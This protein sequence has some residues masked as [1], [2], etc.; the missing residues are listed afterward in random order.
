MTYSQQYVEKSPDLLCEYIGFSSFSC[1]PK[2]DQYDDDYVFEIQFIPAEESDAIL[3]ERN[4]RIQ[5]PEPSD[6][7]DCFSYGIKEENAENI[8]I[9]EGTL[10]FCF[11]SFQ[12]IKDNYHAVCNQVSS[13]FDTDHLEESQILAHNALPLVL[14]P[15]SA[16]E[17]QISEGDLE[18]APYDQRIQV[19]SMPLYFESSELFEEEGSE[20]A[21][22]DQMI[23]GVSLP[24]CFKSSE[25]FKGEEQ[26]VQ[27]S[28][29]PFQPVCNELQV[30]FH[31]LY[32]SSA[33]SLCD[34]INQLSS[35]LAGY[36]AQDQD[37]GDF[38]TPRHD[39]Y[40]NPLYNCLNHLNNCVYML[41]DPFVQ[42][43]D[44]A[45]KVSSFLIFS[46]INKAISDCKISILN[47]SKHRQQRSLMFIMLKWLHWLFHF[48]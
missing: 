41:Q 44:S 46:M 38:Q 27:I 10:P 29:V 33:D 28:Q 34:G 42:F 15:Q 23:Q 48:T 6:Q 30:S 18:A 8:E 45:K 2:Y 31:I 21:A 12:F 26:L 3:G 7:L 11:E 43:L 5:Q 19:V 13:S 32:D 36:K 37:V 17:C 14:Q 9:S 25:L 16:I 1:L 24:L 22:C 20:A 47:T 40:P 35:P 4:V 39:S